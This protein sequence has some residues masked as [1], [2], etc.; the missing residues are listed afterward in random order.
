L[1]ERLATGVLALRRLRLD[2]LHSLLALAVSLHLPLVD[3][4]DFK[5]LAEAGTLPALV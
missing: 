3:H 2:V 5:L 4:V 1:A